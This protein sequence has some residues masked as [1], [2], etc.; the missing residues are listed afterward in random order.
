MST[1]PA[2][3]S[4]Y[5]SLLEIT[6][7][8]GLSRQV[9]SV[10][11]DGLQ[12]TSGGGGNGF[13]PASD[14]PPVHPRAGLWIGSASITNVSQPA[15]VNSSNPVPTA[16]DF[17]FRVLVH[18]DAN[19]QARLL[20]KVL[21]MFKAGTYRPAGDGTTNRVVDQPGRYALLTDDQLI[22]QF[23]GVA[24][25]DASQVGRRF[26]SAAFSF[27]Q[28]IPMSGTADFASAGARWSCPVVLDY[29]DPLNPF[30]HRYHPDH[31]NKNERFEAMPLPEGQESFTVGR[32]VE[33]QFTATD[34]DGLALA[35]WGDNQ[36]GGI[37]RETIS[38]L[39]RST[40]YVSGTFRL[41]Q[42]S[43]VNV[44]NDGL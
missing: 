15:S 28:P 36:I 21:Q 31:D 6:D 13:A 39:H 20:Q 41:Y 11:A 40:I 18:V 12:S 37:Y 19:G 23:T 8:A 25:R 33:L 1:P 42:A 7:A 17:S 43:R 14:P 44:L 34:P 10:V 16:S 24:V 5:Q 2:G 35:G 22:P 26:T 32:Q 30:V 9:L 29:R 38:G 4:R 27:R 3:S